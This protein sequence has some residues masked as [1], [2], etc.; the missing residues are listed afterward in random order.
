MASM[1]TIG[2]RMNGEEKFFQF[3]HGIERYTYRDGIFDVLR[4]E[5]EGA[6]KVLFIKK[7]VDLF[8]LKGYFFNDIDKIICENEDNVLI[9]E[10]C[11]FWEERNLSIETRKVTLI[12][13]S[14][15]PCPA[16]LRGPGY[17]GIF[18]KFNK[19]K[20]AALCL[21]DDK[22]EKCEEK[23]LYCFAN[24]DLENLYITGNGSKSAINGVP[25]KNLI[26]KKSDSI[27]IEYPYDKVC[28]N[29]TILDSD[30]TKLNPYNITCENITVLNSNV[31]IY[32]GV[33]FHYLGAMNSSI[34]VDYDIG[35]DNSVVWL[36][37]STLNAKEICGENA[38]YYQRDD[39]EGWIGYGIN[40][41]IKT[42][43]FL[44]NLKKEQD[45][46]NKGLEKEERRTIEEYITLFHMNS[47]QNKNDFEPS[48][49]YIEQDEEKILSLEQFMSFKDSNY[50]Q[51]TTEKTFIIPENIKLLHLKDIPL[52]YDQKVCIR[53]LNNET[54]LILDHCTF[55]NQVTFHGGNVVLSD[56]QFLDSNNKHHNKPYNKKFCFYGNNDI[57]LLLND[58]SQDDKLKILYMIF[59]GENVD[60]KITGNGSNSVV[61]VPQAALLKSANLNNVKDLDFYV[62]AEEIIIEDS[63][64]NLEKSIDFQYL[65]TTN[66]EISNVANFGTIHSTAYFKTTHLYS[67]S[68]CD[69]KV[70][71]EY[72]KDKRVWLSGEKIIGGEGIVDLC[73]NINDKDRF[74]DRY[75]FQ[76]EVEHAVEDKTKTIFKHC[77]ESRKRT[78]AIMNQIFDLQAQ[79]EFRKTEGF[80]K[81]KR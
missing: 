52:A 62:N 32:N 15:K 78:E 7:N 3:A 41:G 22:T 81:L 24:S 47:Q 38:N 69:M 57:D 25:T 21:A 44:K 28:E 55:N 5:R 74:L 49:I 59:D 42:A 56:P 50:L 19:V 63:K 67:S 18:I 60:L 51:E 70:L 43:R 4:I 1:S 68:D 48:I 20:D 71:G 13:P 16:I 77:L 73:G 72:V 23:S 36:K 10:N 79:E 30:E 37:N 9:L 14:Y 58:T 34:D 33:N 66:S 80:Q 39:H 61:R 64:I 35:S 31:Y 45:R 75:F 2:Y 29:I 40:V 46:E 17:H 54:T 27:K 8:Y 53:F 26:I 11:I 6:Q 12:K 76:Y 65:A